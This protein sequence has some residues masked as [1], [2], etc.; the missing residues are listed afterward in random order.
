M[1]DDLSRKLDGVLKKLRGQGRVSPEN[2]AETLREIRRVLLDADV[3]YRVARSFIDKVME[4]A[5]GEEVM[6]SIT[7]GQLIVKI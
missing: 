4:R 7:P 6:Q 5:A 1:F 2:V 3:N